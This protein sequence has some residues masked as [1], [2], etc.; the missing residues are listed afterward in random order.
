[1]TPTPTDLE[2]YEVVT[3]VC[4]GIAAYKVAGLV[5]KLI[6][7]GAGVS[8]AMT[9]AAQRFITPLTFEALTAR[10]VFT[11]LWDAEGCY[12]PQ[13]LRLTESAD[14]FVVAPATANMIGKIA[15][16]I[17]D[18]LVSTM[19]MSTDCP[20]LLAP[21]AN[22]RMWENPVVQENVQALV[23]RGFRIVPPGEGWLAC[24][25]RGAGRM[26]EP[27]QIAEQ[28]IEILKKAEPK[29]AR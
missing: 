14:V 20:V 2:G 22:T 9:D 29:N 10:R 26:A 16:G 8:V 28:V 23:N 24:R 21:A 11:G 7:R 12:D 17:A 5:S 25:T 1:M 27:D 18:D 19:V 15:H 13:H 3:A 6:Q 4:G